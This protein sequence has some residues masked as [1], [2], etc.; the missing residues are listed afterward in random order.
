MIICFRTEEV[1]AVSPPFRRFRGKTPIGF[2][3]FAAARPRQCAT[4]SC[5]V[6]AIRGFSQFL[7]FFSGIPGHACG[8]GSHSGVTHGYRFRGA[9]FQTWVAV[10]AGG[11]CR[12]YALFAKLPPVRCA[13]GPQARLEC[14][15]RTFKP[16]CASLALSGRN[17][18]PFLF[19]HRS[20]Y[21]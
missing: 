9:L 16:V 18:V 6:P 12:V 15:L 3:P 10:P 4:L 13:P 5:L 14:Y 8:N 2:S 11:F 1:P 20:F 19:A 17:F 21:F 7:P